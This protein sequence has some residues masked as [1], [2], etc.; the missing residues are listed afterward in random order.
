[1]NEKE[2]VRRIIDFGFIIKAQLYSDDTA[3]LRSIMNI[4]I[5]EAED[6]LEEMDA[7]SRSSSTPESDQRFGST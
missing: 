1:M 7:P 3:L 4:M 5:M 6:V 2:L